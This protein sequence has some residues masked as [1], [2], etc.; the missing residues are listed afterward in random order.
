MPDVKKRKYLISM[1]SDKFL[2]SCNASIIEMMQTYLANTI[3]N[4]ERRI[5]KQKDGDK[6]LYF[7]TEKRLAKDGTTWVTEKRISEK[8]YDSYMREADPSLSSVSKKKYRFEYDSCKMEIDIY[9]F[10]A[11]KAIVFVYGNGQLPP[12]INVIQDV[13]G[14]FEYKNRRLARKQAL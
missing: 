4:V 11:E 6:F 3:E 1:P 2:S 14:Y 7:Y 5:R 9:P 12:D 8:E 13:T 10:S